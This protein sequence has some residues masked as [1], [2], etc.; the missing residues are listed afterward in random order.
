M[1]T[2]SM[3]IANPYFIPKKSRFGNPAKKNKFKNRTFLASEVDQEH[4]MSS[5][6]QTEAHVLAT[7]P[8]APSDKPFVVNEDAE[9]RHDSIK[10]RK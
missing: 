8:K 7:K 1:R 5:F 10:I 2:L 6:I 4:E 9:I 3:R